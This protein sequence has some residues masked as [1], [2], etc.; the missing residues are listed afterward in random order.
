[1][2]WYRLYVP[3]DTGSYGSWDTV[4]YSQ[5]I[6]LK[7]KQIFLSPGGVAYVAAIATLQEQKIPGSNTA[8]FKVFRYLYIAAQLSKL[9]ICIVIVCILEK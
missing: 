9:S 1:M 3:A 7:F 5:G 2:K 4:K 6:G 8:W